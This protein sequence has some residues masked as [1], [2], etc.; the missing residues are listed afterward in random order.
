M[1]GTGWPS[2]VGGVG[3]IALLLAFTV[4]QPA[5]AQSSADSLYEAGHHELA[6]SLYRRDAMVFPTSARRWYAVGAASWAAGQDASAAAAWLTALRLAP[7][8][9]DVRQA[10]AQ[11]ARFSGDLQ[12]VGQVPPFTPSELAVVA[13]VM[14]A[15][16]WIV[17]GLRR[18]SSAIALFVIALGFAAGA[19]VLASIERQPLAVLARA[20]QLRDAPHGLAEEIGRAQELAVVEVVEQRAAWRLIE[21]RQHLRGWIPATAVVEVRA[22]D[23]RP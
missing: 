7:R 15:L 9:E 16:A 13:A 21:T 19:M 2:R 22:L 3:V 4:L 11:I 5:A 14:W 18:R 23:S 8:S 1:L 12:R 6:A 17:V 10:W 20:V